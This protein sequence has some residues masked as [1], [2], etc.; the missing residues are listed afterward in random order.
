VGASIFE[1]VYNTSVGRSPR[2]DHVYK[3]SLWQRLA[4][5]SFGSAAGERWFAFGYCR[6]Q[7]ASLLSNRPLSF[8][9][10]YKQGNT[11]HVLFDT[12]PLVEAIGC[13]QPNCWHFGDLGRVAIF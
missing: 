3:P 5:S 8:V 11:H 13:R 1:I 9:R 4:R 6:P 2:R 10:F 12:S 7:A